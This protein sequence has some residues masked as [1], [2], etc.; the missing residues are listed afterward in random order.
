MT[1]DKVATIIYHQEEVIIM[2]KANG[3]CEYHF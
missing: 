3:W 1:L 2:T